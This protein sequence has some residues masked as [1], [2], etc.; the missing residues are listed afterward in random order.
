MS[1]ASQVSVLSLGMASSLTIHRGDDQISPHVLQWEIFN[2]LL[3]SPRLVAALSLS[4][5]WNVRG[6]NSVGATNER[7]SK[8]LAD[9][10][11]FKSN[12]LFLLFHGQIHLLSVS[13]CADGPRAPSELESCSIDLRGSFHELG[14]ELPIPAVSPPVLRPLLCKPGE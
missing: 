9:A 13:K 1:A 8:G 6:M 7:I 10:R 5:T 4:F 2:N 3:G 11:S 14:D 12:I